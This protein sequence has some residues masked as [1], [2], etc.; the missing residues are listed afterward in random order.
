[1]ASVA[2][3]CCMC[4]DPVDEK[5]AWSEVTGWVRRRDQGGANHVAMPKPLSRHMCMHCMDK[6]Q[7]GL[8]PG[9]T[10]LWG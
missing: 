1:M 5:R 2:A 8:D 3:R 6:L 9:Q 10:S 7:A 4:N